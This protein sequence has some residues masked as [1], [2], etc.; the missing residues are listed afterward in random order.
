MSPFKIDVAA[1][2][3]LE[4]RVFLVFWRVPLIKEYPSIELPM[5]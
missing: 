3:F 4:D 5:W 2:W 1:L